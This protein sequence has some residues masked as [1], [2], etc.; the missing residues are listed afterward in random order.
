MKRL[1]APALCFLLGL[2]VIALAQVNNPP[3]RVS[4]GNAGIVG[5]LSGN[6]TDY[7]SGAG[8]YVAVPG[9]TGG[10]NVTLNTA[11]L[12]EVVPNDTG[13]GTTAAKLV[14]LTNAGK[15]VIAT[16][17]DTST[18][19]G[20][21]VSGISGTSCGTSGNASVAISGQAS[22]VFDNATTAGDF[23][24][25]S[26]TVNGD[27]HDAGSTVPASVSVLGQVLSTNGGA[28]TYVVDISPIGAMAA[29][30]S[31]AKP[32]G[33]TTQLQYNSAG[34]FAGVTG[35]CTVSAGVLSCTTPSASTDVAPK[36]YVD[37]VGAAINPA[38]AVQAATTQASDTSG[39]TYTH[40]AGI[41]DFFTGS[42]NTAITVDGFTFTAVNQ[43]LLVKNDTQSPSGAFNGVYYVTTLQGVA[44]A[45]V[46]TRAL[47]Y[48]QSSDINNTGAIPVVNGTVN[49][50]TSWLL[51]SSVTTVG[52]D[53]LTYVQFSIAPTNVMTLSTAQ[54]ATAVKTFTNSDIALLG[55]S[56]GKTTFTSANSSATNYTLTI[57]AASTTI[58][59]ATQTITF[60]GPSTA[61]TYTFP[62]AADTVAALGTTQT[63]SGVQTFG[64]VHGTT[65]TVTLTSNNYNAVVA[66]CGKTKLLPTGTSPTVTLPNINVN[67]C[68]ITFVTTV[69]KSYLFN[70]ASGGSKQNSQGFYNTRGTAAGD[71]VSVILTVPSA[72]AATWNV[73][74]DVTS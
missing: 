62:D 72:S 14:K 3:A 17:S 4:T 26:T 15:V 43:R 64:E 25:V 16:T 65:E 69:T 53:P 57:P 45:P 34:S 33:S 63:F 18:V 13:T 67:A 58:P 59:V 30:N 54:T 27:C 7:L 32:G 71:T 12:I 61:R 29:L 31:K 66:D 2:T 56:T 52:T 41:G 40:I 48:D 37:S 47:D 5:P 70:A 51:T 19:N 10:G 6:A 42:V 21:C 11:S 28:G 1:L 35:N 74:G 46:L 20:I 55:S 9:G 60:A 8:T 24:V 68:T 23:V 36:S 50:N 22:C 44:T 39:L 38:V 73:A 49:A